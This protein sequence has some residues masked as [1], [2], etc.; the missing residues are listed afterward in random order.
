MTIFQFPGITAHNP[1]KIGN[2]IPLSIAP[3][4]FYG[5]WEWTAGEAATE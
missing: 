4:I 1:E 3:G 5:F 2:V